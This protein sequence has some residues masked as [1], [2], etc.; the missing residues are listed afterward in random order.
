VLNQTPHHESICGSGGIAPPILTSALD[1]GVDQF[2][3]PGRFTPGTHLI[4]GWVGPRV[5]LDAA[6]KPLPLSE[7]EPQTF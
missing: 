1:G 2:H 6:E 7:I 5:G 3:A 4:A